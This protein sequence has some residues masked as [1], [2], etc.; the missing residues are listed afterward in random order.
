MRASGERVGGVGDLDLLIDHAV[1]PCDQSGI[2][3]Q[4]VPAP[5]PL[6]RDTGDRQEHDSPS[7]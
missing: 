3:V 5:V 4:T 7:A 2:V 1:A 6:H